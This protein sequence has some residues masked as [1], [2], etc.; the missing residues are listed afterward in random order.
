MKPPEPERN[1]KPRVRKRYADSISE[2]DEIWYRLP[3][4]HHVHHGVV[5][6]VRQDTIAVKLMRNKSGLL[7]RRTSSINWLDRDLITII[8]HE[9]ND[10]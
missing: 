1:I 2:G 9:P 4:E 7:A 3:N 5:D 6:R 10:S 8:D